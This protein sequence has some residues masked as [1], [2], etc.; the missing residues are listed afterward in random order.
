MD[1]DIR[2]KVAASRRIMFRAGLDR[3]DVAGQVTARADGEN[4]FWTSPLQLFDQTLPEQV[5]KLP[6]DRA[7]TAGGSV[8]AV[9]GS[10]P[11]TTAARWV[12]AIYVS[13][14][15]VGCVIHTHAPFI[16]A[17]ATTGEVLGMYNNR[18]VTFYD[19]SLR[20]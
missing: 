14:P 7:T 15:D 11:V 17:V 2:F 3:D 16:G 18:S 9:D 19:E 13:R 4:A 6:F 10:L 5:V 12:E 8:V 20:R 1:D